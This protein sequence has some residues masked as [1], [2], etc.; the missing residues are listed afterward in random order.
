M[1]STAKSNPTKRQFPKRRK[2]FRLPSDVRAVVREAD[3]C[4]EIDVDI[5]PERIDMLVSAGAIPSADMEK[6]KFHA[7][8]LIADL[9]D[10]Q[11]EMSVQRTRASCY[12]T[13][14][15]FAASPEAPSSQPFLL[16]CDGRSYP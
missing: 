1:A 13:S 7:Q 2:G 5:S 10:F 9:V 15:S 16:R 14:L 12:A 11:R 4:I 3:G 6:L 8:R